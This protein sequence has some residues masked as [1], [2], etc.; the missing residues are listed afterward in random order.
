MS[1]QGKRLF[2]DGFGLWFTQHQYHVDG[3]IHGFSDTFVGF[4]VLFD[5]FRN[6]EAGHVHKD[7]A[8]IINNGEAMDGVTQPDTPGC[9]GDFR[10]WEGRDDFSVSDSKSTVKLTYIN[11]R[12]S[13][14]LD[15]KN[16]GEFVTCIQDV[17]LNLPADWN[18]NAYFG[19]TSTT[20]QLADNHDLLSFLVSPV[21]DT[22]LPED[23]STDVPAD[24]TT[25]NPQIDAVVAATVAKEV[26]KVTDKLQH[27]HHHLEHQLSSV[28]DSLKHNVKK[29]QEQ[30]TDNVNRI[31]ELESRLANQVE[32][33]V[34]DTVANTLEMTLE[35]RLDA[36]ERALNLNIKRHV[37]AQLDAELDNKV[38][39]KVEASVENA[40]R[41]W[42]IPFV[43]LAVAL[44]GVAVF[45]YMKYRHVMKTHLL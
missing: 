17:P 36:V 33:Q 20:G 5:T 37:D 41:G 7:V 2:G 43:L 15:A 26:K 38:G 35:E 40:G 11:G 18:T 12:V 6:T 28:H 23:P 39:A 24:L 21:A 32:S 4:G 44:A 13:V 10:F 27:L 45:G 22:I 31:E 3:P 14:A 19:V 1:G 30:E 42:L 34:E 9:D 16:T 8:L 29:L 25:G